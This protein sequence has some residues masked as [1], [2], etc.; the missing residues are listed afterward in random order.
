MFEEQVACGVERT[1]ATFASLLECVELTGGAANP[2]LLPLLQ[3][4]QADN[5]SLE[6]VRR[7]RMIAIDRAAPRRSPPSAAHSPQR[8]DV[9]G[10]GGA[11]HDHTQQ[12]RAC[13]CITTR[14]ILHRHLDIGISAAPQLSRAVAARAAATA[15]TKLSADDAGAVERAGCA[16][17]TRNCTVA[18]A[19]HEH[20]WVARH[21]HPYW[22]AHGAFCTG[23]STTPAHQRSDSWPGAHAPLGMVLPQ[24]SSYTIG[25]AYHQAGNQGTS[26]PL[27]PLPNPSAGLF[28]THSI[29][30]TLPEQA[31]CSPGQPPVGQDA[32]LQHG[33]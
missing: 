29:S 7:A 17:P 8:L 1:P 33:G 20:A 10:R 21:N 14:N 23:H 4:M 6:A 24:E 16:P 2:L 15:C 32:P 31:I 3:Q 22:C 18:G 25:Q 5:I 26:H 9:M 11:S 30:H 27:H 19:D 13:C 28:I 12:V